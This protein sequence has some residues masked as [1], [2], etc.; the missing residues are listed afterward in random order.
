LA[1]I[2]IVT[3]IEPI[4]RLVKQNPKTVPVIIETPRGSRNK[5]TYDERLRAFKLKSVLPIGSSFPYDFGF[6]PNTR[7]DDGDPIDVLVLMDEPTFTGCIVLARLIGV[8]QAEQSE[9]G[10]SFRNDRL[11][12]VAKNSHEFREIRSLRSLDEKLVNEL[13]QFFVSYNE[14]R[15]KQFNVLGVKG[16][17][18]ARKLVRDCK[19]K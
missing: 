4:A 5:F 8:I 7:A 19:R 2:R 10:T 6:V 3:D 11:I 16:C 9:K 14:T 17:K 15:G 18:T 12:A 1:V 13:N